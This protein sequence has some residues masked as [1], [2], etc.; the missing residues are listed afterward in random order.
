[1]L[2]LIATQCC[3][4]SP[5][6]QINYED[7]Y[8]LWDQKDF[9]SLSTLGC[10][11]QMMIWL[12]WFCSEQGESQPPTSRTATK[13]VQ[14]ECFKGKLTGVRLNIRGLNKKIYFHMEIQTSDC[15]GE[16]TPP[17]P[18]KLNGNYFCVLLQKPFIWLAKLKH[19]YTEIFYTF[20]PNS[21]FILVP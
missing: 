19:W 16:Y 18:S 17:C 4:T 15:L 13:M 11:Y 12:L 3:I 9:G 8:Q 6:I 5:T 14:I 1:M 10:H 2:A 20:V 7:L 21:R